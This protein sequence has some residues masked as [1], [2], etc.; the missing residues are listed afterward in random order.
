LDILL[1]S[2]H[3]LHIS[4]LRPWPWEWTN[5]LYIPAAI[6]NLALLIALGIMAWNFRKPFGLGSPIIAFG[7]SF[8]LILGVL[9]GEV[10]PVIGAVVRY[11]MPALIFLF[12]VIFALTDHIKLQR[13]LPFL[14]KI[15]KKL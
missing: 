7:I 8:I 5:L 1:A 9:I 4:Y 3:A 11:K 10:V 12:V 2:P 15:L 6:E 14:R 13:R